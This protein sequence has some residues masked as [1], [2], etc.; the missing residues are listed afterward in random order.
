MPW[1]VLS[2]HFFSLITVLLF[3]KSSLRTAVTP[4]ADGA[5]PSS[6]INRLILLA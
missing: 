1:L 2:V 6:A 3:T 4:A 5:L